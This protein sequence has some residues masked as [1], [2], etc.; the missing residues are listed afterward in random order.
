MSGI[1]QVLARKWRPREFGDVAGQDVVVRA[2]SNAI[3]RNRVHHAYLFS[4]SRGTGKTTVAR[5]LARSLN[6]EKGPTATPCGE[7]DPCREILSGNSLDVLEIDGASTRGIDDVRRLRE[8]VK[9]A[10][11]RGKKKVYIVDEVHMLTQQAFNA[12]LKTLEEPPAHVV[13]V[14]ATTDPQKLPETILS[15]CQRFTFTRIPVANAVERLREVVTGEGAEITEGAL[16]VL[17]RR[18]GGALRDALGFLDQVIATGASPIDEAAVTRALGLVGTDVYGDLVRAFVDRDPGKA[19]TVVS[20]VHRAGH[21]LEFF[22]QGL[23]DVLRNLLVLKSAPGATE[24]LEVSDDERA[25][26]ADLAEPLDLGDLLRLIR[27]TVEASDQIRRSD[28]PWV[29]LEVSVVEMASL[30]RVADLGA[31][32][33]EL[34]T[35]TG[36]DGP[37]GSPGGGLAPGGSGGRG[38]A[39]AS[40][41]ASRTGAR[42]GTGP[43]A[44]GQAPTG[45]PDL[46]EVPRPASGGVAGSTG[47]PAEEARAAAPTLTV[48]EP[49]AS[50]PE[51]DVSDPPPSVSPEGASSSAT[52]ADGGARASSAAADGAGADAIWGHV[53]E[54][55]KPEKPLL[56]SVLSQ[57][58]PGPIENDTLYFR[59]DPEQDFHLEQLREPA[60]LDFIKQCVAAASPRPLGFDVRLEKG[61]GGPEPRERKKVLED[62]FVKKLLEFLDGEIVE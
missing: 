8:D 5:I 10:P 45:R 51:A 13:F 52:P 61:A 57:G 60:H 15:R 27:I 22:V 25:L 32:V 36:G 3:E 37:G 16:L 54:R 55:V 43:R 28:Y 39:S 41:S 23:L 38:S 40:G 49:G 24:I 21:D 9:L 2:L 42:P 35:L 53:L 7:C 29:H 30:D 11:S 44:S 58:E 6:C 12:L 50:V 46:R 59:I 48:A 1:Y 14:L 19:L 62:P 20:D 17:A 47:T 33:A 31:L 4:G 26:L 18:A 56:W 34:R